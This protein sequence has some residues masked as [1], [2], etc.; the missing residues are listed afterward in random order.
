MD[1]Q[2]AEYW[3]EGTVGLGCW[4]GCVWESAWVLVPVGSTHIAELVAAFAG[5]VVAAV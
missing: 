1:E 4:A 2:V 5:Y 3:E